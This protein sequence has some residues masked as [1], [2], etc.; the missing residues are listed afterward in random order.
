MLRRLRRLGWLVAV[1]ALALFGAAILVRM[2]PSD[3]ERWHVDPLT[4]PGTGTPNSFRLVPAGMGSEPADAVAPVYPVTAAQL[5]AAFDQMAM[6]EPRTRRL[7][8][9]PAEG[10]VTY[11]QRSRLFGFPDYVS[12][13]FFDLPEGGSSLAIF[14]RARFGSGDLGVNRARVEKW[15]AALGTFTP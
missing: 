1:I 9:S 12:V 14:S 3:P 11:V 8:G 7:A 15:L 2:A 13:R 5:A 6:A 4:A 10:Q